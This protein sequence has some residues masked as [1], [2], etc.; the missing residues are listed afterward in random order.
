MNTDETKKKKKNPFLFIIRGDFLAEKYVF[1]QLGFVAYI[2]LLIVINISNSYLCVD[3]LS[4]LDN[5]KTELKDIK[6]ENLV[7][8]TKLTSIS[9]QSQ[10]E[11]MLAKKGINLSVSTTPAFEI[12]K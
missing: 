8:L 3:E 1:N 6:Y 7:I 10:I 2:V 5:L 12:N 9:R 11:E 4:K